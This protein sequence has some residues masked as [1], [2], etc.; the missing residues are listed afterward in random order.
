MLDSFESSPALKDVPC[1]GAELGFTVPVVGGEADG[2]CRAALLGVAEMTPGINNGFLPVHMHVRDDLM[3]V[4]E[5]SPVSV[6]MSTVPA[7]PCSCSATSSPLHALR[8]AQPGST[9][10]AQ[11]KC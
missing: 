7:A 8:D 5:M 4:E 11:W 9:P 10:G 3:P 6:A 1:S 2:A